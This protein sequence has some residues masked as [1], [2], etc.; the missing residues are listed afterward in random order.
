MTEHG[1]QRD[2]D[3]FPEWLKRHQGRT[4]YFILGKGGAEGLKSKLNA[5]IPGAGK[6]VEVVSGN[7]SNKYDLA[8][9]RLCAPE[10]CPP[11]T[12]RPNLPP[13]EPTRPPTGPPP[14]KEDLTAP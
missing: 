2:W 9:G 3:D 5:S 11:D 6:T 8:R 13:P 7:M 10:D 4:Y 14:T 1:F 12:T